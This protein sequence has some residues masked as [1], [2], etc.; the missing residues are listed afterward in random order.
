MTSSRNTVS[1]A[2]RPSG[3]HVSW[4]IW[5]LVAAAGAVIVAPWAL[6]L[7]GFGAGGVAASSLAAATQSAV[8]GGAATGVFS[9]LQSAG[10]VGAFS[11]ATNVAIGASAAAVTSAVTS[12]VT[13]GD[14]GHGA[15]AIYAI[16]YEPPVQHVDSVANDET[17][18][19]PPISKDTTNG[20]GDG[21]GNEQHADKHDAGGDDPD[22]EE[23]QNVH[24]TDHG[25]SDVVN[26]LAGVRPRARL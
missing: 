26:T 22:E 9:L 17:I 1:T 23:A 4:P 11:T 7:L 10:A 5:P 8:Y 18:D 20:D 14:G 21:G 16:E 3:T 24:H 6:P 25:R 12:A 13:R 15:P 2:V 19:T